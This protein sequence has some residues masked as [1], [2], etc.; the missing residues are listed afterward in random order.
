[1]NEEKIPLSFAQQRLWFLDQLLPNSTM[2]NM[3]TAVRLSGA[4]N[5][6]A[7][8]KS[9][10]YLMARHEILRTRIDVV[11]GEPVQLIA[12]EL[13]FDLGFINISALSKNESEMLA[14]NIAQAEVDKLFQLAKGPLIRGALIKLSEQEHILLIT[15]HHIIADGWSIS[16]FYRE[17][18]DAYSAYIKQMLPSLPELSIQYADY[19]IWQRGWLKGEILENQLYYWKKQFEN[20]PA[21]LQLPTDRSRKKLPSY[22]GTFYNSY[23]SKSLLLEL[24]EF[25]KSQNVTLFMLLLTA[26]GIILHRY[27]NQDDIVIGTPIANR[28]FEQI[29][30]LIGF[31]VNTLALKINCKGNPSFK[32]LLKIV[33]RTTLDAYDHQ[34]LPFEQLVES[35]QI[36]PSLSYNPIF[37]VMFILQNAGEVNFCLEGLEVRAINLEFR[38]SKFD[39]TLVTRETPDGLYLGFDYAKDL[40]DESTIARIAKHYELLLSEIIKNPNLTINQIPIITTVE[41]QELLIEKNTTTTNFLS[42]K[43][44]QQFFEEQVE[45]NPN[46]IALISDKTVL[47]YKELNKK[48]NQLAYY[49]RSLGVGPDVIV[50]VFVERSFELIIGL[51]AILKAGGTYLPL[52]TSYP[53]NRLTYMLADAKTSIVITNGQSSE[54]LV[55]YKGVIINLQKDKDKIS[56]FNYNNPVVNITPENLA[57]VIYTSGST[58]QPKG[59]PC[60]H[61]NILNR[62]LWAYNRYPFKAD[63]VCCLQSNIGFVDSL[64]DILGT[65]LQGIKLVV[66]S[67][68]TARNPET[69][70]LQLQK[71]EVT[72]IV[73]TPSF[74]KSILQ[75]YPDLKTR[76]PKLTHWEITGEIF[77]KYLIQSFLVAMPNVRLLDV[78]GAT[79]A[80]SVIYFELSLVQAEEN[81]IKSCPI[82][83]ANTQIYL[84]DKNLEPV[85]VGVPGEL[86]IGGVSI[87]GGY[88]NKPEISR[89]KFIK[90]IFSKNPDDRLYKTGD[91]ARYTNDNNIEFLGRVDHQIKLR[92]FR[93]EL[94]EIEYVIASHNAIQD[95]VVIDQIDEEDQKIIIAFI[96]TRCSKINDDEALLFK[97][98]LRQYIAKKLPEYMIPSAFIFLDSLPLNANG[99]VDRM[100]LPKQQQINERLTEQIYVSPRNEI[101][102]DLTILW[103]SLLTMEKIG[104]YDNFFNIGGHSLL[105]TKL[106]IQIR[107]KFKVELPLRLIFD[108][109]TI[110]ELSNKIENLK[111]LSYSNVLTKITKAAFR[112]A[113]IPLSFAQQR[114]WFLDQILPN[115]SV[116]NLCERLHLRGKL[117][118]SLL[119]KS[120]NAIIQRH[121]ILQTSIIEQ[122]G[123]AQQFIRVQEEF[124]LDYEDISLLKMSDQQQSIDH[125]IRDEASKPFNLTI[126]PLIRGQ[127]IRLAKN[128]HIF[129]LTMHHII[130]DGW[131]IGL[132]YRELSM[133]YNGAEL[134]ALP[135]I[136]LQYADFTIWQ[137]KWLQD[138]VLARQL[139]YWSQQLANIPE[140][141]QLSTKA[142]PKEMSYCGAYYH[143]PLSKTLSEQLKQLAKKN[144]VTLFMTLLAIFKLLLHRY[145][146][147][148]DIVVGTPIANRQHEEIENLIGLFANVLALRINC[149]GNPSFLELL[150]RVQKVALEAYEY[151][152]VPFEQVVEHLKVERDLSRNPVFQ[153]MFALQ[154]AANFGLEFEGLMVSNLEANHHYA[155][156]DLILWAHEGSENIYLGFEYAAD[157]FDQFTIE[158][159]ALHFEHLA[160]EIIF[161]PNK[162]IN[163]LSI[164]IKTESQKFQFWNNTI[165][166]YPIQGSVIELFEAQVERTPDAIALIFN[167]KIFTYK[168]LNERI[169]QLAYYLINLGLK[170]GSMVAIALERSADFFISQLAIM[171]SGGAYI[172]LDLSYPKQRLKF[173]LE[174]TD[175]LILITRSELMDNFTEYQGKLLNIEKDGYAI[176]QLPVHNPL[177]IVSRHNLAYVIYTSGSTG[178]P[179]GVLVEQKGIVNCLL[180]VS[181][182]I[183]ANEN[184]VFLAITSF[185]FDVSVLDCY[186]PLA[187]GAKIILAD[188]SS[189]KDPEKIINLLVEHRVT[190]MQATP[191][192]WNTLVSA[193]WKGEQQFKIL[194][195]GEALPQELAKHL[196]QCGNVFNL[197]G[198]TEA[199]IYATV[200]KIENS[201]VTIGKPIANTQIFILDNYQ[202]RVPIGV[203]GELYIGGVGVA[204][205]YLNR[206]DLT[207]ERFIANPFFDKETP[208]AFLSKLYRTGDLARY[209]PD[210]NIEYIGRI[211]NQVKIRGFRVELGEIET[212]LCHY[213]QIQNAVVIMSENVGQKRLIAYLVCKPEYKER[214]NLNT[215]IGIKN[216]R[217]YLGQELPDYMIPHTFVVCKSFPLNSSGKVDRKSLAMSSEQPMFEDSYVAPMNSIEEQLVI[218]WSKLL[219][220]E[221]IGIYD[222]FFLLGGDS[223]IAIQMVAQVRQIGINIDVKQVFLHP[224]IN[225][226]AK[227]SQLQIA[228]KLPYMPQEDSGVVPLTAIQRWFFDLNFV[229]INYA[230]QAMILKANQS[231]DIAILRKAFNCLVRHHDILRARF[232]KDNNSWCQQ[233]LKTEEILN[234]NIFTLQEFNLEKYDK[235]SFG[236]AIRNI[237]TDIHTSLDIEHGPLIRLVIFNCGKNEAQRILIVIHHLIVDGVS[238]RILLED[239]ELIYQQ[240]EQRKEISLPRKTTSYKSWA[241]ALMNYAQ[242]EKVLAE[243]P[244]WLK[245][246]SLATSKFL[247]VDFENGVHINETSVTIHR[248]IDE[249]T[250]NQLL[251][252]VPKTYA[253]HI[254][255][256]LVTAFVQAIGDWTECYNFSFAFDGHGRE[257]IIE[258]IDLSRT[259]GWFTA[260]F[261]IYI[262]LTNVLD[263][264]LAIQIV[265]KT[266]AAIP[267]RGIGYEVLKYLTE[268]PVADH[269]K[270]ARFPE[271]RFNYLG[272][273]DNSLQ[274]DGLFSFAKESSGSNTGSQ[275]PHNYILDINSQIGDGCLHIGFRYS[276]DQFKKE[277]IEKVA[278]YFIQRLK[279]LIDHCCKKIIEYPKA[280]TITNFSFYSINHKNIVVMQPH[281]NQNPFFCIHPINGD[282]R[283]YWAMARSLGNE[284]PFYGLENIS[285]FNHFNYSLYSMESLIAGYIKNIQSVKSDGPYY[286]GGWSFGAIAAFEMN[287]QLQAQGKKVDHLIL[288]DPPSVKRLENFSNIS[289]KD[290]GF[291]KFFKGKDI[292][293]INLIAKDFMILSVKEQISYLLKEVQGLNLINNEEQQ[294]EFSKLLTVHLSNLNIMKNYKLS[295][296]VEK[297]TI[298]VSKDTL[299]KILK[300]E[301]SGDITLGWNMYSNVAVDVHVIPGDHYSIWQ[302]P[303]V[304]VMAKLMTSVLKTI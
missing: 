24:N 284:Q 18:K 59:V 65:L 263:L 274:R 273:W 3:P 5:Q 40:F 302:K 162:K 293:K 189:R 119:K 81:I 78:Y 165:K 113:E 272:Q 54:L 159:M 98:N 83:T 203:I 260:I 240:L 20:V 146:S 126:S 105:A 108:Y 57:Y 90:N 56:K 252:E 259:V 140:L 158:H 163:E 220:V 229:Q 80:T 39:L 23:L 96:V 11:Q 121:E 87:A 285:I 93:I 197:Y 116:Y 249:F 148:N 92:G 101:E 234:D 55:K 99:K 171:K 164:L 278:D 279:V 50:G 138:E 270:K 49:L 91:L 53:I 199:S 117:D 152:D 79:E 231:L 194:S 250:T 176:S 256:I 281:G 232:Y 122:N 13:N 218:I 286:L 185:G 280:N 160:N 253:T 106:V 230:N 95:V 46:A 82:I 266:L 247:P 103:Q 130:S 207:E 64:W 198:P 173:I 68:E 202:Q 235:E 111:K 137:R 77:P 145:T 127:L 75:I 100:A 88:L 94:S 294:K 184:D 241:V 296:K 187:I 118:V 133:L 136:S 243:I 107:S 7:L 298:F 58:G 60:T 26:F 188:E 212:T 9:L 70:I 135:P 181:D 269:L 208:Q 193:T 10:D 204:R 227:I 36:K 16:I 17:L 66:Y 257:E 48:S 167:K 28:N 223:I 157:L 196:I 43:C 170:P 192:V 115:K 228:E 155:R 180:S 261:P 31:F 172:P 275:N 128:E 211:D 52:D 109:P 112:P 209:L 71:F 174:D 8:Q 301:N 206:K 156:L 177:I 245:S 251:Y 262:N 169:N 72:R 30:N 216:L 236:E 291:S 12:K 292:N 33:R 139:N 120:L 25:A 35:L 147:Y 132:F 237:A 21:L 304:D 67:S 97:V 201:K 264:G 45:N 27:S 205:G 34:D 37:Q 131:S 84:L 161:N 1:M 22:E 143:Y 224:T 244:Y 210:G 213:P 125:Y 215:S 233:I 295:S 182:I 89:Q 134:S 15:M 76:L 238:W 221:R 149:S 271:L 288:F 283:W 239:F 246:L 200:A 267:E 242:S 186:L 124:P 38:N 2:Y 225:G 14:L 258:E 63:D 41:R 142:R 86:Y 299:N 29:E 303:N 300:E 214:H 110:A 6:L 19:A 123:K 153:I 287:K 191:A 195:V 61:K 47:S 51:L 166:E 277:T 289:L 102:M 254:N 32:D 104:I 175:A 265:K 85:P 276:S 69:L 151:Q 154:N 74:L 183:Q 179:K 168:K 190:A 44:L 248:Y 219:F 144:D 282:I 141:L 4:L 73:L 297:I 62:T 129:L 217:Q 178:T 268:S 255:D 150:N 222:N 226:L 290:F 42:E 114:L